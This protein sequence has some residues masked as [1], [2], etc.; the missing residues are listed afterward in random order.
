[1]FVF[2]ALVFYALPFLLLIEILRSIY[3]E[4]RADRVPILLY[5]RVISRKSIAAGE[6][7]DREPIYAVYDDMFEA[8][9]R[10][11]RENDYTALS[12]DEFVEIRRGRRPL[13]ARSLVITFDD[14]YES[15]YTMAWPALRRYDLSATIFVAPE[16]DDYSRRLVAGFDGF[17]NPDQMRELDA[18][19]VAIESHTLTH[20]VLSELDDATARRE[21]E[22]CGR[23]LGEIL[24]R[25][26]RHLAIPRSGY[27]RRIKRLVGTMAFDSVCC[28]NKGSSNGLSDLQALPRIVIERD[29]TV[30]DFSQALRP[31]RAVVLRL[32]G[33]LKRIPERLFGS[34]GSQRIRSVLYSGPLAGLFVTRRLKRVVGCGALIYLLGVVTFT[35]L[36]VFR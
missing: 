21:L 13:P 20:C 1:M 36:I 16:P 28:N 23:V 18:G 14:G 6:T 22:E 25:P 11:L 8:Q 32:L 7:P 35:W 33:N 5:H 26:L 30:E 24:G 12:L 31:R 27:S 19:G 10:W 9:M 4:Y 34:S 2:G 17:L 15:N 3:L 29:M